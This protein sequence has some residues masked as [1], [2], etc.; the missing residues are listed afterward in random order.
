M[1]RYEKIQQKVFIK[2]EKYTIDRERLIVLCTETTCN[3]SS[4]TFKGVVLES[5]E[6]SIGQYSK[7]WFTKEFKK[8]E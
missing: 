2:G 3:Y 6:Y 1:D 7:G 5:K 8:D 4:S